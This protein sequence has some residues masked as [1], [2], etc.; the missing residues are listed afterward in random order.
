MRAALYS[1]ISLHSQF[2]QS[3]QSVSS[4]LSSS[5]VLI[6]SVDPL[7]RPPTPF[8]S[9]SNQILHRI[10]SESSAEVKLV[11]ACI[12]LEKIRFY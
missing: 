1:G 3:S 10:P 6:T 11:N 12:S 8:L 9:L 5:T 4:S 7:W 2:H